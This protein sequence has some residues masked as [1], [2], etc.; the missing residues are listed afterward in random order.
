MQSLR[1]ACSAQVAI[2]PRLARRELRQ[3]TMEVAVPVLRRR[4]S[5]WA[6]LRQQQ[7]NLLVLLAKSVLRATGLRIPRPDF[8][9][10]MS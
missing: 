6:I 5:S 10:Q 9:P 8:L 7:A 2:G 1:V 4:R 3:P